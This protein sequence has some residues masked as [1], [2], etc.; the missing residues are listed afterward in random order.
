[1]S[2]KTRGRYRR[3][4]EPN[5]T[6]QVPKQTLSSIAKRAKTRRASKVIAPNKQAAAILC[7]KN[8]PDHQAASVSENASHD[9][10]LSML[11]D[12]AA[13]CSDDEPPMPDACNTCEGDGRGEDEESVVPPPSVATQDVSSEDDEEASQVQHDNE[14]DSALD[15]DSDTESLGLDD[16]APEEYFLKLSK[17]TLPSQSTTKAEAL[18]LIL[19]YVVSAGLT[20]A[21]VRGL[22]I[23]I[24]AL[25]GSNVVPGS[26]Y[27]FR[28]LWKDK[29]ELL[30]LHF[31]PCLS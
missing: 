21:Q 14:D 17:E 4:L 23:L 30:K 25:I 7:A 27:F 18:L 2:Q 31:L 5:S 6:E 15:E 1:M 16:G 12:M 11:P 29:K 20:W 24:N 28:K 9:A 10:N 19:A 13:C 8:S 26:T 3:Y 22:L